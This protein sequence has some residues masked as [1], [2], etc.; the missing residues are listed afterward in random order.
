MK[1]AIK[2]WRIIDIL[3]VSEK[4]LQEKGIESPRLNAELLLCDTLNSQRMKLYLDFERPLTQ[5]ELDDY[6]AKIKRRLAREPLQYITGKTGFY[7]LFFEVNPS[8][9]IPRPESELLVEK[10]LELIKVLKLENPKILEI[11]TG[12]G[13]ISIAIATHIMCEIDAI[14]ISEDALAVAERNSAANNTT[15]KITFQK[16]DIIKNVNSFAGYD[17]VISNPPYIAIDE[18]PALQEE[19][20]N[21][22]PL[23]ALTDNGDGLGFYRKIIEIGKASEDAAKILLEIGDGKK[24]PVESLFKENNIT[25]Y[26]FSKDLLN[27]NRVVYL[28]I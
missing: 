27:I 20:K 24:E 19:V 28:E 15:E 1:E 3:K 18:I 2:T 26:H 22:E 16:K 11:G 6:R 13:C 4:L 17:L 23:G 21:F 5:A 8:V 10:S 14:D 25:A 9:L 12:S 7:G